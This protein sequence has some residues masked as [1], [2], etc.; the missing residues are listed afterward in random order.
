MKLNVD[1]DDKDIIIFKSLIIL[2]IW[3][4]RKLNETEVYLKFSANYVSDLRE[5][6]KLGIM[7]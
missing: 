3:I 2:I 7:K 1:Y 6:R 5:I 4:Y